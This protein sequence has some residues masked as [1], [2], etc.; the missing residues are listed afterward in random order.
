MANTTNTSHDSA[1]D[2][3]KSEQKKLNALVD[4]VEQDIEYLVS[5]RMNA[6]RETGTHQHLIEKIT[7]QLGRPAT[8][9]SLI[10]LIVVWIAL[11]L[12]EPLF[13]LHSFDQPPFY[14]L[15]GFIGCTSILLTTSVLIS[16][17]R[18]SSLDEQRNHLSLEVSLLIERKVSKLIELLADLR[19][20]MQ[21]VPDIDD[22][23][24][25]IMKENVD[26]QK[27][28]ESYKETYKEAMQSITQQKENR[29]TQQ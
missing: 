2:K 26:P 27:V 21:Q 14:Y 23:Q 7:A 9:Y 1:D 28:M 13:H 12:C 3:D 10:L 25:D 19:T 18:Q 11:N 20:D 15:Q 17:N 24:V 4:I 8:F 5:I 16:Q 29:P 22:P 6:E